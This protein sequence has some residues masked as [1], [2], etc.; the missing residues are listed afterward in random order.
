MSVQCECNIVNLIV[1]NR[2]K[3]LHLSDYSCDFAC[4]SITTILLQL[5]Y[6]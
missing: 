3:Y 6:D 4:Q 5:K 2:N 1:N